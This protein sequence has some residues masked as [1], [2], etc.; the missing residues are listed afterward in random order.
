MRDQFRLIL[1]RH[2]FDLRGKVGRADFWYFVLA[3]LLAIGATWA[4]TFALSQIA[5]RLTPVMN[6]I[7]ALVALGLLPPL[8]GMGARR[9]R[10]V[11]QSAQLVWLLIV[12][13]AILQLWELL[14]GVPFQN[15]GLI[16]YSGTYVPLLQFIAFAALT[17]LVS[18][19]MQPG[20]A[21][22]QGVTQ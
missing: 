4:A 13:V 10:D 16:Y 2:Y 18:F 9:L 21:E 6:C 22:P 20:P 17:A 14:V 7:Y 8:A 19:W 5:N 11:G 3:C 15:P 12:P 1:T